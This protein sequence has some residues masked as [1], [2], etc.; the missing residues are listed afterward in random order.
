M[1]MDLSFLV[2]F[3]LSN[4]KLYLILVFVMFFY[5]SNA[6]I[7]GHPGELTPGN[8]QT[9]APRHLQISPVITLFWVAYVVILVTTIRGKHACSDGVCQTPK[10]SG[11][12]TAKQFTGT[13]ENTQI[14]GSNSS[15]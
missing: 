3:P 11:Y 15:V 2:Y 4:L 8:P 10:G 14:L 6:L 1:Y 5:C 9:F 13:R 7:S 12:V